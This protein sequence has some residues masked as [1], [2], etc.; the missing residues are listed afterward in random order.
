MA[1]S[2]KEK[3]FETEIW[4]LK[5]TLQEAHN[6]ILNGEIADAI[7]ALSSITSDAERLIDQLD[8]LF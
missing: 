5:T 4:F 2:I 3:D 7:E 6:H 1:S 8:L